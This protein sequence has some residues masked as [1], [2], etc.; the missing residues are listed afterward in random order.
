M[1]ACSEA[2]KILGTNENIKMVPTQNKDKS[3]KNNNLGWIDMPQEY[4][5][6]YFDSREDSK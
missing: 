6:V 5:R 4:A 1:L 3:S 2:Q